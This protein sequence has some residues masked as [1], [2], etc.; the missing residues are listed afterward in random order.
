MITTIYCTDSLLEVE[1][2]LNTFKYTFHYTF[3][4]YILGNRQENDGP[5]RINDLVQLLTT[6]THGGERTNLSGE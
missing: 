2:K 3:F 6:N 1:G 4:N 5:T